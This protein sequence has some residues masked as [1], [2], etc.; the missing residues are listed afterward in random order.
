[1]ERGPQFT[2]Y[3]YTN[4]LELSHR[5]LR[6]TRDED[7]KRRLSRLKDILTELESVV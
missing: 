2:E 3:E 6:G 4:L 7:N 1:M 5:S